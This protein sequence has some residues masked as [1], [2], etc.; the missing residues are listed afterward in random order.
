MREQAA[1][2]AVTDDGVTWQIATIKQPSQH[3]MSFYSWCFSQLS[4]LLFSLFWFLSCF[5][6]VALLLCLSLFPISYR[7]LWALVKGE[8][9][10]K[11]GGSN[12]E[13]WILEGTCLG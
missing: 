5:L 10:K 2:I 6:L 7:L 13:F 1:G 3:N 11:N 12:L 9:E 4:F 8:K